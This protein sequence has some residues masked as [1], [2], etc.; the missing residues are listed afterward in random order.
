MSETTDPVLDVL[1][2]A[3]RV[4]DA[5]LNTA[6]VRAAIT[7]MTPSPRQRYPVRMALVAAAAVAVA[8]VGGWQAVAPPDE[9]ISA[10]Q[11]DSSDIELVAARFDAAAAQFPLPNGQTYDALRT[12]V[13]DK[14]K[15]E[16][17][18]VGHGRI[19]KEGDV[20]SLKDDAEAETDAMAALV[21]RYSGC[22]WWEIEANG[23]FDELSSREQ[24]EV[25]KRN[26]EAL[27]EVLRVKNN[28]DVFSL[29]E[30]W[31]ELCKDV[32]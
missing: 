12:E 19:P 30:L 21:A 2:D 28:P 18:V 1:R 22:K 20:R 6:E 26:Q 23:K 5:D 8:G 15:R 14:A 9:P 25:Q 27:A 29:T 31:D 17:F 4:Q 13:L 7:K 10:G 11:V 3:A 32:E 24:A 16:E